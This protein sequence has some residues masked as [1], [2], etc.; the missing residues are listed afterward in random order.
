[1]YSFEDLLPVNDRAIGIYI[2]V[3]FCEIRCSYC[4][5][6]TDLEGAGERDQYFKSLEVELDARI[7]KSGDRKSVV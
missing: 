6:A 3:P 7:L 5:F 4:D 2:H 1:M